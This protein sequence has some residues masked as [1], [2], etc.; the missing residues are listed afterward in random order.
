V[1]VLVLLVVLVLVLVIVLGDRVSRAV[2]EWSEYEYRFAAYEYEW[3]LGWQ[4]VLFSI[5][6][7]DPQMTGHRQSAILFLADQDAHP[8]TISSSS[9]VPHDGRNPQDSSWC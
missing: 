6:G 1:L 5:G 2:V 8:D 7:G 9:G 4:H 3:G